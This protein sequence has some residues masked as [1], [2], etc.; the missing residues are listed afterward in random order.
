MKTKLT[1]LFLSLFSIIGGKT[2]VNAQV[3]IGAGEEPELGT[4][5]QLKEKTNIK[6]NA[7]NA[8]RGLGLPR[9]NLSDKHQLYPMFLTNPDDPA[10]GPNSEYAANKDALDKSH[11]GLMVYNTGGPLSEGVKYWD[12]TSWADISPVEPWN[13]SGSSDYATLNTQNI[14]Q[15]GAVSIGSDSVPNAAVALNVEANDKGVLLPRVELISPTDQV[16]I[17]NPP[18]GLMVYNKGTTSFPTQGYLYWDG[19]EWKLFNSSTSTPPNIVNLNC[20]GAT[21]SPSTYQAG[22]RYSGIVKIPYSGGNGGYYVGT[23]SFTSHGLTF[24]LQDGKLENGNGELVLR[25]EGT[26]DISSPNSITIPI[27]GTIANKIGIN[28]WN[29]TCKVKVG[30]QMNADIKSIA[31]MDYMHFVTDDNGVKGFSVECTTPDGLYTVRAFLKHSNQTNT[32]TEKNNT[33]SVSS[34]S[35]N[36]I[37]LRNNSNE[38]KI[39]M[40]NYN[41]EYGDGYLGC[42][43]NLIVPPREWGGT[44]SNSN[45]TWISLTT[46][47]QNNYASWGNGGI[48]NARNEGPEHRRYSWID[49]SKTT[50]VAYTIT[51]MAGM[52]PGASE[53]NPTKQKVFIKIE[54]ITA[55]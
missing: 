21:L 38:T 50:K 13:I 25:V 31:V 29:G 28:F 23:G 52:D 44:S 54:Q 49:T 26:P 41:T 39:L 17:P 42:S 16:T 40:W 32:A 24:R 2:I 3:T 47:P 36:N 7:I 43:G 45:S 10:S 35:N 51:V 33:E 19:Y 12:G 34:T 55:Q 22:A 6:G 37:Q 9:V 53:I 4:L 18:V 48:Y 46:T 11:T 14:Y 5:L 30:H 20:L 27:N 1:I 15:M 8:Y